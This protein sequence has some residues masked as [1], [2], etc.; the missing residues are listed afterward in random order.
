MSLTSATPSPSP[1]RLVWA[2]AFTRSISLP[3]RAPGDH[4]RPPPPHSVGPSLDYCS[5]PSQGA[6]VGAPRCR[7][8]FLVS[9][10]ALPP[11]ASLVG[12][13]QSRWTSGVGGGCDLGRQ[14]Q[15]WNDAEG[16]SCTN[17]F[18]ELKSHKERAAA[19][20]TDQALGTSGMTRRELRKGWRRRW[21]R[22]GWWR[23]RGPLLGFDGGGV[24]LPGDM[25]EAAK[26]G[27]IWEVLLFHYFDLQSAL[28]PLGAVPSW[29]SATGCLPTRRSSSKLE[30]R[31]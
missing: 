9:A 31:L 4:L 30:Q 20:A 10:P 5:T 25:V 6:A 1:P 11:L 13:L 15:A 19:A 8:A 17:T 2:W 16:K 21:G 24:A 18:P 3:Q 7:I 14:F 12:P 26:D 29:C 23:L 27:V 22:Q 28:W